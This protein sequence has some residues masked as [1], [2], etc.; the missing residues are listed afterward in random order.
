MRVL[1]AAVAGTLI[2]SGV[3]SAQ[4]RPVPAHPI[5]RPVTPSPAAPPVRSPSLDPPPMPAPDLNSG[6]EELCSE[7][8][9]LA[10]RC[11]EVARLPRCP[12]PDPRCPRPSSLNSGAG[13]GG[14][15]P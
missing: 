5:I 10:G 13:D 6:G 3:A 12:G 8:D 11:V 1:A 15:Q 4:V 14:P 9:L 7:G 2:F